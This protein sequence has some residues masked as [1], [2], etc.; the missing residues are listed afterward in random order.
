MPDIELTK[1]WYFTIFGKMTMTKG[2]YDHGLTPFRVFFQEQHINQKK[3]Y[4]FQ[5]FIFSLFTGYI[6]LRQFKYKHKI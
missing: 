4:T 5:K 2:V 1:K 3:I 6:L